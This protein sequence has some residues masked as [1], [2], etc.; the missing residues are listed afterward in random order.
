M[1]RENKPEGKSSKRVTI[2]VKARIIILF[3]MHKLSALT[4]MAN[5]TRHKWEIYI[6]SSGWM[7]DEED[8]KSI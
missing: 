1:R 5:E 3:Y 2:R 7:R 4:E 8:I 6:S